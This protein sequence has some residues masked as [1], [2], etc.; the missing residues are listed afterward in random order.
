MSLFQKSSQFLLDFLWPP[1]CVNCRAI[2]SWL[3]QNCF[4]QIPFLNTS[5]CKRCGIPVGAASG[6]PCPECEANSWQSIDGMRAA[7]RFSDNPI[8]PAIHFLKYHNHRAITAILGKILVDAYRRYH[9]NVEVIVPVP[10]HPSR[11]RERGYNQSELL[12]REVGAVLNL[13]VNTDGLQRTR[14]TKPQVEL[15][16]DER[17]QNV[18]NAFACDNQK[19]AGQQVLLIDDVCTTGSTLDACAAALK[20]SGVVSVWGLT[21]ARAY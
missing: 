2:N 11:L 9:L 19:L 12:A 7:S 17:R 18:V 3:C 4:S 14:K 6:S 20:K 1:H 13:T 21:L 5:I 10:L 15:S 16:I 8:R